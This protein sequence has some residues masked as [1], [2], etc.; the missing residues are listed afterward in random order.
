VLWVS[1]H[2]EGADHA[3]VMRSI[4]R[5]L[6]SFPLFGL[7]DDAAGVLVPLAYLLYWWVIPA[8][9]LL[10]AMVVLDTWQYFLHRGMHIN[11]FLFKH[12]HSVHHRLYV[13]YAFGALYNHPLEGF[14]LDTLGALLSESLAG[15]SV[16]QATFFFVVSTCK[17]VDDHCGYNLPFDP[18]QMFSG[19]TADYHDIHHQTIG[20][21]SNFSQPWFV[22][23]DVILGTRMTRQ[24][25]EERRAKFKSS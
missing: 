1:E 18:L 5:T 7:F 2:P 4:A 6:A 11:R 16:R 22:H 20:I 17:T 19:N 23:W 14:L 12:L 3:T 24:D 8:A 10:L 13:P 21:K 15:L 25:I 9:Q